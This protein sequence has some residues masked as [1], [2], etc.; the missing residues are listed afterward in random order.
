MSFILSW[1]SD[2]GDSRDC[3]S[4]NCFSLRCQEE[5]QTDR[6]CTGQLAQ[7]AVHALTAFHAQPDEV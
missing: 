4:T 7:H 3:D 1:N 2:R 5:S 6:E